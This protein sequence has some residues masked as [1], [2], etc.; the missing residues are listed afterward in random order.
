MSHSF[1]NHY[2]PAEWSWLAHGHSLNCRT[3]AT[4][5]TFCPIS[6]LLTTRGSKCHLLVPRPSNKVTKLCTVYSH[7]WLSSSCLL[8]MG[9]LL[10]LSALYLVTTGSLSSKPDDR[11][12][13]CN[14]L[15]LMSS[16]VS[17]KKKVC[18]HF[19]TFCTSLLWLVLGKEWPKGNTSLVPKFYLRFIFIFSFCSS[20]TWS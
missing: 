10:E 6:S 1:S 13:S 19:C 3:M 2:H 16:P 7:D 12:L 20:I 18:I 5:V 11:L 9:D 8:H 14:H 4:Y 15:F 17:Q